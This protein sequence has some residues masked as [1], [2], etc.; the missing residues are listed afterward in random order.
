MHARRE[1]NINKTCTHRLDLER[2]NRLDVRGNVIRSR[3]EVLK[4]LLGIVN[5]RFILQHGTVVR[6][7]DRRGLR[8]ELSMDALGVGVP[9]AEGLEGADGFYVPISINVSAHTI[10][11]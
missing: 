4:E 11:D 3:L 7:I 5:N 8:R 2:S 9:F 1:T 6:K 10:V